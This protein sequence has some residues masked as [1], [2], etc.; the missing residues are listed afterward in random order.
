MRI[1]LSASLILLLAS[2]ANAG[3]VIGFD[4][5]THHFVVEH[6]PDHA[7][8][9]WLFPEHLPARHFGPDHH[10]AKPE[11]IFNTAHWS[12]KTLSEIWLQG[13][14]TYSKMGHV[15][16]TPLWHY[17]EYR[18]ELNPK[19]F[20]FYHPYF[21]GIFKEADCVGELPVGPFY[22]NIE[23]RYEIDPVRFDHYHPA[24]ATIMARNATAEMNCSNAIPEPTSLVLL[25]IGGLFLAAAVHGEVYRSRRRRA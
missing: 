14:N 19:R 25:A 22:T 18:Y 20:G 6:I 23:H 11:V 24:L 8:I 9:T 3:S 21:E 16:N 10:V 2:T 13:I 17:L 15:P 1:L 4:R 7:A 5:E 12:E